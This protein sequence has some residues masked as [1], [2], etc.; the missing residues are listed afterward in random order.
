MLSAPRGRISL[1]ESH[2]FS[3]EPVFLIVK[4]KGS[5]WS[6]IIYFSL[7][8]QS[9]Y[10]IHVDIIVK[11]PKIQTVLHTSVIMKDSKK[12]IQQG[13]NEFLARTYY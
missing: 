11:R 1:G 7:V 3:Q 2:H 5:D 10:I 6:K 13:L 12:H 9:D 8:F 4:R